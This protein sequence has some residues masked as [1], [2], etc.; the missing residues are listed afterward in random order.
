MSVFKKKNA[1]WSRIYLEDILGNTPEHPLF[2]GQF[3]LWTHLT[4][5]SALEESGRPTC[6]HEFSDQC[7]ERAEM[8]WDGIE[9]V[10]YR[11]NNNNNNSIKKK[12]PQ[13]AMVF[14]CLCVREGPSSFLTGYNVC[15]GGRKPLLQNYPRKEYYVTSRI[16]SMKNWGP[17]KRT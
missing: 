5:H 4:I 6:K 11:Q 8:G 2:Q 17:L 7:C 14:K 12:N 10:Y 9:W 1:C 13:G 15:P 16:M 3:S